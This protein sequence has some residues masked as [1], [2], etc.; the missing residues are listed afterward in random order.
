MTLLLLLGCAPE[1]ALFGPG[2]HQNVRVADAQLRSGGIRPGKGPEVSQVVRPQPE[3]LRGDAGVGLSGRLAPGGVA[4]LLQAKGDPD[5]WVLPADGY[6]FVVQDELLFG[7][8]LEFSH[9]IQSDSV[10]LRLAATD[11]RGR[12]GPITETVFQLLPD[13]P[14]AQLLVSLAWDAPVDLDLHVET[15]D[16]IVIGAKNPNTVEPAP[17]QVLTPEEAAQGGYL[18]LDSNEGCILD[19][20]NRENVLWSVPPPSGTYRIYAHLFSPCDASFANMEATAQLDGEL[21]VRAAATQYAFDSREHPR[22]GR[23]PGLLLATFEVP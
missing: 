2:L 6:D 17:G 1:V 22:D 7:T 9:A 11:D 16:G 18:E 8:Q 20:L 23:A 15:P 5:H 12:V 14:P 3:V 21:L 13:A 19:N 4:L 10:T